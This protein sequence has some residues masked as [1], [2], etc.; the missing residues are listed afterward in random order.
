MT[1]TAGQKH[2][3]VALAIQGAPVDAVAAKYP[4]DEEEVKRIHA[5][6]TQEMKDHP[7]QPGQSWSIG[8]EW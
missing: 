7:L 4:G 1:L 5:D 2:S 6:M 3:V 8:S